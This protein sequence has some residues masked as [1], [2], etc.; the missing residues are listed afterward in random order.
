LTVT[1]PPEPTTAPPTEVPATAPPASEEETIPPPPAD[2]QWQNDITSLSPDG[3]WQATV[4]QSE[5]FIAEEREWYQAQMI[6][7]EVEGEREWMVV[8]E[9]RPHGLGYLFPEVVHWTEDGASLLFADASVADGCDLFGRNYGLSRLE[10]AS[11]EVSEL[12]PEDEMGIIAVAPSDTQIAMMSLWRPPILITLD[13]E[14]GRE[15]ELILDEFPHGQIGDLTWAPDGSSLLFVLAEDACLDNWRHSI[16]RV[17]YPEMMVTPLL[18][19][20]PNQFRIIEW[21]GPEYATLEDADGTL[22][23]LNILSGAVIS[24]GEGE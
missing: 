5:P 2:L 24:V 6:V 14:A 19:E 15:Q 8:D 13:L 18:I 20:D 22:W 7:S 21:F 23:T 17:D 3:E 1:P 9:V 4:R 12:L 16:Y 10:L 11:G